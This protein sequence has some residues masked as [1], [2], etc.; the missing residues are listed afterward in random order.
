MANLQ[1]LNWQIPI[2][3]PDRTP[4]IEFQRAWAA[5]QG[6]T[7]SIPALDTAAEVSA[8]LDKLGSTPGSLLRRTAAGWQIITGAQGDLLR[9]GASDWQTIP[10]PNDATKYLDGTGAY[11]GVQTLLNSIGST[12]GQVL[13]RGATNWSVLPPGTAGYVLSTNGAGADPSWVAQTGG[14]GGGGG[15]MITPS[16]LFTS[17][18][19]STN[20][21][22]TKGMNLFLAENC[23]IV[24][25]RVPVS[26]MTIGNQLTGR[27]YAVTAAGV[28]TSVVASTPP[29]ALTL[30]T[31]SLTLPFATPVALT[32]GKYVLGVS[33]SNAPLGSSALRMYTGA[34]TF[35]N[36]ANMP[37]YYDN[38]FTGCVSLAQ[39]VPAV[40]NTFTIVNASYYYLATK[41]TL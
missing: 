41:F 32:P 4:T 27:I 7:G 1:P 38:A 5:L 39:I 14:G 25:I 15:A 22:A 29:V 2:V 18:S 23:N 24:D 11:S 40:G 16:N 17:V 12:R 36:F 19:V 33:W 13:F 3:D 26:G 37:I 31:Q 9:R 34:S 20:G 21:T 35:P 28:I 8:V 10:Y 30:A 6:A